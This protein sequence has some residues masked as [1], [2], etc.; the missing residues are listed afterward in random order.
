MNMPRGR[1]L[2]LMI[3]LFALLGCGAQRPEGL[4]VR[5][6]ALA[7]C[8]DSPNCVCSC[9]IRDSHAV[10]P[11]TGTLND[12][13]RALSGMPRVNIV[14]DADGYLHAEF[15]TR[16]MRYVDDVEFLEDSAAGVV[17]IRSASRVGHSDLGLNRK[18][19]EAIRDAVNAR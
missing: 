15:T 11:V 16:L 7:P 13:R 19:V 17:H 3:S 9:E 5:A 4:G 18:R 2:L 10:A 6:G 8:P 12:V 1:G 14:S